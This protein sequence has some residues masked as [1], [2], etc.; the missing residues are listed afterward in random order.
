VQWPNFDTAPAHCAVAK[1]R[2]GACVMAKSRPVMRI[3]PPIWWRG[4]VGLCALCHLYYPHPTSPAS[5]EQFLASSVLSTMRLHSGQWTTV[6]ISTFAHI[7]WKRA[8]SKKMYNDCHLSASIA[9]SS[10]PVL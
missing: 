10:V 2:H 3:S 1:S 9:S 7:A 6:M 4:R 8:G 5:H